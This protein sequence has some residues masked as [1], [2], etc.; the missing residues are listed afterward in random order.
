MSERILDIEIRGTRNLNPYEELIKVFLQPSEYRIHGEEMAA[1]DTDR[2]ESAPERLVYDVSRDDQAGKK[3][4]RY[5][6][7]RQLFEDLA[8]RTGKRP[9]WGV[10]TGIRPVK[11]AG[12][13]EQRLTDVPEEKRASAARLLLQKQYLLHP[14]KA[15]LATEILRR[16]KRLAGDPP[17]NS[18][19]VYIGIP[20]CPTRCLYCS[21]TSNQVEEGE[22]RR[23]LAALEKEVRW[24]GQAVKE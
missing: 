24:S 14:R 3:E 4:D 1:E 15:E 11:L 9:K 8:V 7:S 21:F 12:E 18:L 5:A 22:I 23:Y 16:Q 20:F 19:S 6:V 17:E 2:A 10:L 13:I